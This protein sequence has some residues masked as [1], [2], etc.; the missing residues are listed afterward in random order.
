MKIKVKLICLR[1]Y[2]E[3]RQAIKSATYHRGWDSEGNRQSAC[4]DCHG[5]VYALTFPLSPAL[6]AVMGTEGEL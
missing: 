4:L 1:C 6:A 5:A 3:G 2:R